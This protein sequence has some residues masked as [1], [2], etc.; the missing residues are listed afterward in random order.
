MP[1]GFGL[2]NGDLDFSFPFRKLRFIIY[3][4]QNTES[5]NK[6]PSNPFILTGCYSPEY[7]YGRNEEFAKL[8]EAIKNE[9]NV[10]LFS[11]RRLG[12]TA[13]IQHLFHFLEK[14]NHFIT[15]YVDI[16]S[17]DSLQNLTQKIATSVVRK[18]GSIEKRGLTKKIQDFIRN[19][20]A[21]IEFDPVSGNPSIKFSYADYDQSKLSLQTILD[22]LSKQKQTVVI[23][24]DEFHQI[25]RYQ[26]D[27]PEAFIRSLVQE[28]PGIRFIF[29]GSHRNIMI[30]LFTG[31][32]QPFY[33]STQIFELLNIHPDEYSH[34][35]KY[36]LKKDNKIIEQEAINRIFDWTNLQTYYVQ[37][38]CNRLYSSYENISMELVNDT[39]L[40]ILEEEQTVFSNYRNLL[41]FVQWRVLVALSKDAPVSEPTSGSFLRKHNISSTSTMSTAIKALQEKELIIKLKGQYIIHDTLLMRWIQQNF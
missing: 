26:E 28:F 20:G 37:L 14:D 12:K 33:R 1:V 22:F 5:C 31:P 13:L 36:H 18:F 6:K 27:S 17:T 2:K 8:S 21:G 38:V 7:F 9:R 40:K 10:T 23:A 16:L 11:L 4:T 34:F 35:I 32:G 39:F 3:A 41:T 30:S 25:T 29:S 24:L 15:L 19:I